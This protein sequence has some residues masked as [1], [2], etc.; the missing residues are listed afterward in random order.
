MYAP[1][2]ESVAEL[3]Y[4][5]AEAIRKAIEQG[6]RKTARLLYDHRRAS[7]ATSVTRPN[8]AWH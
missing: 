4:G 5:E 3:T 7:V 2:E 8:C 6:R 1:G